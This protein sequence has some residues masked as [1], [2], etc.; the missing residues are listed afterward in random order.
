MAAA[1]QA[2]TAADAAATR[3]LIFNAR[4]DAAICGIFMLLVAV[5]LLDSIRVWAGILTGN[6]DRRVHEAPFV[7]SRLQVE[8][9]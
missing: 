2:G 7:V 5:I 4:L 6:G 1:L 9:L 3:T 8:E